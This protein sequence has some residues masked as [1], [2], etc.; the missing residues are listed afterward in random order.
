MCA[1]AFG[2][3]FFSFSAVILSGPGALELGRSLMISLMYLIVER[4]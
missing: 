4:W 2:R 1:I 3:R